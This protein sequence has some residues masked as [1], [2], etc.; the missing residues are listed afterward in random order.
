MQHLQKFIKLGVLDSPV[1]EVKDLKELV[2]AT[3]AESQ[4]LKMTV[5]NF[6]TLRD[7]ERR[8]Q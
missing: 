6:K 2:R 3:K 5:S 8:E 7:N 1:E 4:T